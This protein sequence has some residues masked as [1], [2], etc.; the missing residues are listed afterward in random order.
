MEQHPG[1]NNVVLV[2]SKQQKNTILARW[3]KIENVVGDLDQSGA[4]CG[5]LNRKVS[6]SGGDQNVT[7]HPALVLMI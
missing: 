6:D 1:W 3:P 2:R 4:N 7:Q 5:V